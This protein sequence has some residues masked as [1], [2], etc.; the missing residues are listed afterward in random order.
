MTLIMVL[1]DDKIDDSGNAN[2]IDTGNDNSN[3]D[4]S[5]GDVFGDTYHVGVS[6][7]N[8]VAI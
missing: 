5:E 7:N 2:T 1:N 3:E 6:D 8:D 4:G